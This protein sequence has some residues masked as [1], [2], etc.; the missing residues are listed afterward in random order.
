M[1]TGDALTARLSRFVQSWAS[2]KKSWTGAVE[3]TFTDGTQSPVARAIWRGCVAIDHASYA[4]P[5]TGPLV[6][7]G[8]A[9]ACVRE[10][11]AGGVDS[12]AGSD[13]TIGRRAATLT[14]RNASVLP[15]IGCARPA[16]GHRSRPAANVHRR[17]AT[18]NRGRDLAAAADGDKCDDGHVE[19]AALVRRHPR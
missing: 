15:S 18:T 7:T 2:S 16:C 13:A 4:G 5:R 10:R 19:R 3:E 1:S 11:R 8:W 9:C 14:A 12:A 6:V 17:P